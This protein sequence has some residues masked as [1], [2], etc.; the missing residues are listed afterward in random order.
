M[1]YMELR[2][3]SEAEIT[4]EQR[5]ELMRITRDHLVRGRGIDGTFEF[6]Y[7]PR[8]SELDHCKYDFLYV[9]DMGRSPER[10]AQKEDIARAIGEAIIPVLGTESFA[11]RLRLQDAAFVPYGQ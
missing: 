5:D 3:Y 2:N 4:V 7:L 1:P 11:V 8:A 9:I 10:E 6:R